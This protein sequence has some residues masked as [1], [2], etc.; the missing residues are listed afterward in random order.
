M[1]WSQSA[2]WTSTLIYYIEVPIIQDYYSFSLI[3]FEMD[4]KFHYRTVE[5]D[6]I[7]DQVDSPE[8][9][10]DFELGQDEAVDIKDKE[11][12]KQ[13]LRKRI[14]QFKVSFKNFIV[15]KLYFV[16]SVGMGCNI[17]LHICFDFG[18]SLA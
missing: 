4:I 13:K 17:Y 8:I 16:S 5:D 18:Q 12:N 1:T 3:T 14:D 11:V 9:V 6:I 7:V 15:N 10:D 2:T